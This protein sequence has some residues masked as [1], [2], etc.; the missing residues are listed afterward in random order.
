LDPIFRFAEVKTHVVFTSGF[1][2]VFEIQIRISGRLLNANPHGA[3]HLGAGFSENLYLKHCNM[4][5]S[6]NTGVRYICWAGG[7]SAE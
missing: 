4:Q 7:V 2:A 3:I 6:V 1:I 5:L